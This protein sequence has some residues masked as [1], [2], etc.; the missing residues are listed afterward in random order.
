ME[1]KEKIDIYYCKRVYNIQIIHNHSSILEDSLKEELHHFYLT[2][3]IKK[4]HY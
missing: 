2:Q 4:W 3:K 1:L